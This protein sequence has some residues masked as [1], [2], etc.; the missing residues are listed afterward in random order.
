MIICSLGTPVEQVNIGAMTFTKLLHRIVASSAV[1]AFR[2]PPK[3]RPWLQVYVIELLANHIANK[4]KHCA[5]NIKPVG[6]QDHSKP[7]TS[8]TQHHHLQ[9][10]VSSLH[11]HNVSISLRLPLCAKPLRLL[12]QSDDLIC[13]LQG[14]HGDKMI[15]CCKT[16]DCVSVVSLSEGI[17]YEVRCCF[18]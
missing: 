12:L 13:F 9:C 2:N 4:F 17:E 11:I 6:G 7:S 10:F 1:A 5:A 16:T 8:A 15:S 18:S 3:S 14:C